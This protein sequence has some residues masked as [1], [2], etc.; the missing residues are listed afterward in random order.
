MVARTRELSAEQA[1]V[2]FLLPSSVWHGRRV[3]FERVRRGSDGLRMIRQLSDRDRFD[4]LSGQV[5]WITA[6]ASPDDVQ[7]VQESLI[8]P[9]RAS[10]FLGRRSKAFG[11]I[12]CQSQ[13]GQ[14]SHALG[15]MKL[16][17]AM[18]ENPI[19]TPANFW[20][21]NHTDP[22]HRF[23]CLLRSCSGWRYINLRCLRGERQS[24]QSRSPH[25]HLLSD[26]PNH[27]YAL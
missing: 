10:G 6:I 23:R 14:Q 2:V 5:E 8:S 4:V 9:L 15:Q 27:E 13:L 17:E 12:R 22:R 18:V 3:S 19:A 1:L 24:S 7:P 16:W 21:S 20:Y 25:D 26:P 11:S